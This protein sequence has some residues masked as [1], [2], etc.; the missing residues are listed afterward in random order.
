MQLSSL[1]NNLWEQYVAE[2]LQ[3]Q[4]IYNLFTNQDE[5]VINDHVAF[6]TFDDSRINVTALGKFF[7]NLGYKMC[8][9]YEFTAKKLYARHYEHMQDVDQPKIFISE[10]KTKK[11]YHLYLFKLLIIRIRIYLFKRSETILLILF[12]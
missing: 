10:L 12:I 9:E 7:E 6:R 2:N 11:A 3:A 4:N 1:L 5:H 8:G